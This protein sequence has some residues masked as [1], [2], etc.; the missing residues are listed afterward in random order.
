MIVEIIEEVEDP[1]REDEDI[2]PTGPIIWN[3]FKVSGVQSKSGGA[4]N[5]TCNFCDTVFV[6]CSS[7]RAFAHILGRPVLGQK[8]SNVKS[9]VPLRKS[10]DN[11]YVEFKTAQ[12]VLN[13]EMTSKE[14]QLS[15]SKANQSVLNFTSL[16]KRTV[17]GE[18]KTVES[19][20]LDS[21]ASFI[22][23]NALSFNVVDSPS[24]AVMVDQCIQFGQ[25]NP[26]RK[27]KVPTRRRISG[28]LLD[29]AYED[30]A[31]SVKLIMDRAKKY[32]GTLTSDGWSDVQRRPITNFMLV[33]Y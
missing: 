23:E 5:V 2:E 26:G 19:K 7:S 9:C 8:K 24:F 21:I 25:Q 22:F 14:E 17:T 27:Y 6:G 29:S 32:G 18:M 15:S 20:E 30:T 13:Q 28:P 1:E 33:G 31:G 3:Y 4:K 12:K 11:R 16:G 10:D